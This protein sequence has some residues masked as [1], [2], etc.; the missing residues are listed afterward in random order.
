MRELSAG[1]CGQRWK[2]LKTH[3]GLRIPPRA[4]KLQD[5]MHD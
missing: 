1:L 3:R 4:A 5:A 2:G